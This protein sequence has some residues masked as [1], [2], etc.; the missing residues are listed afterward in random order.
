M[1][2]IDVLVGEGTGVLEGVIGVLVRVA[3]GVRVGKGVLVG[4]GVGVRVGVRVAVRVKV[5]AGPGLDCL[6]GNRKNGL[7][8]EVGVTEGVG[9]PDPAIVAVEVKT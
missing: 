9:E 6:V 7:R 1:G 5:G 4:T 3:V 2:G 8:V